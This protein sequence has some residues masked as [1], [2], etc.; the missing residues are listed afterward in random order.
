MSLIS[1][2][3]NSPFPAGTAAL[4]A[5]RNPNGGSATLTAAVAERTVDG[6]LSLTTKEGDTVTLSAH[7]DATVTYAALRARGDGGS[8]SARVTTLEASAEL[9]LQV[10]GDLSEEELAD[11]RKVVKAFFHELKD[12]FRGH[13]QDGDALAG[14]GP[15]ATTLASYA[16]HVESSSSLTAVSVV[17]HPAATPAPLPAQPVDEDGVA[18][19]SGPAAP[20]AGPAIGRLLGA[21]RHA[22]VAEHRLD[23]V[24]ARVFRQATQVLRAPEVRGWL[25]AVQ[26]GL[27][28]GTIQPAPVEAFSEDVPATP[29]AA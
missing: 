6:T 27:K 7:A 26:A 8:F 14:G 13:G 23:A 11:I 24:L 5:A 2:I 18:T 19:G 15:E 21:M 17:A 20:A 1:S 29:V 10:Q 16:V 9:D 28:Q 12:A 22:R 4:G 3:A 25:S